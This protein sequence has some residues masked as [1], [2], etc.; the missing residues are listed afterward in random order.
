MKKRSLAL[1]VLLPLAA[2]SEMMAPENVPV[3][4]LIKN[5]EAALKAKPNDPD[6]L[7]LLA[8]LHSLAYAKADA[9]ASV[10]FDRRGDLTS[11][12]HFAPWMGVQDKE[13]PASRTLSPVRL[14]HLRSSYFTYKL[15]VKATPEAGLPKLGWAWVCEEAAKY[16][17]Q[18]GDFGSPKK[19]TAADFIKQATE[20]YRDIVRNY[21][22]AV[23]KEHRWTWPDEEPAYEAA[24]NLQRIFGAKLDKSEADRLAKVIADYEARPVVMSPIIFPIEP[25][26]TA[27]LLDSSIT[28]R[29]DIAADGIPRDW[30]WVSTKTA[31]LAW[32]PART[33]KIKDATQ[34]FGNRTFNMFFRDGYAALTSLDNNRDGWLTGAELR[35]LAVWH[36]QNQN[37]VSDRGEVLPVE[38]WG[39]AAIRTRSNT[40]AGGMLA[41]STGIR[42]TSGRVAPTYDWLPTSKTG[43]AFV[44][45][46]PCSKNFRKT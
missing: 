45:E 43:A 19:F 25:T 16:P 33:G 36:D 31:F 15:A 20:L 21:R 30:P 12:F 11:P 24:K 2:T 34:L 39:I 27:R 44:A 18:T 40:T 46:T 38:R 5:V 1:L 13:V 22:P 35:G 14:A 17:Q 37:G 7:F 41:A 9:K 26:E 10:Y 3:E 28:T 4:R 8:R 29:F 32:D 6:Q 23:S 42:F